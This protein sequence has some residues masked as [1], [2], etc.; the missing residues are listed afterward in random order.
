MGD[1]EAGCVVE[2]AGVEGRVLGSGEGRDVRG[3][4]GGSG[5]VGVE[6]GMVEAEA[7]GDDMGRGGR[8]HANQQP[9]Q[10]GWSSGHAG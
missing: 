6:G 2:G 9:G 5:G 4:E 3:A 8:E 7:Q 10:N 1:G